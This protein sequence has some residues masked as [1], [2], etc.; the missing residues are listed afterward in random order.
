MEPERVPVRGIVEV[1]G[2]EARALLQR[3]VTNDMEQLAPGDA[4]YAAL[5]TPQGK[6]VV[7]FLAVSAPTLEQPERFLL[8]CPGALAGALARKLGMYKLR[9]QVTVADRSAELGAV[10]LLEAI[11]P[12]DAGLV[13]Y[14]DPRNAALGFRAIGPHEVLDLL[15]PP[16]SELEAR[17]IAAG[18]PEGGIDFPYEDTF[19]HEAN[20][21]RLRGV[22]FAKGCYVGQEV[23]SRMEHRGTARKR[24]VPVFFEGQPPVPGTVIANRDLPVGVMGSSAGQRGLA[25][26]RLDRAD[27]AADL[28]AGGTPI[29]LQP[30]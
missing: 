28:A 5:L 8:D 24:V 12:R 15:R 9:A 22:D 16:L 17:R 14:G 11:A 13:V 1:A 21:D 6:I 19:P 7:D 18:V 2:P 29:R 3:L 10:P 23:V 4:R 27:E 20:L 26:L 25:L 30:A